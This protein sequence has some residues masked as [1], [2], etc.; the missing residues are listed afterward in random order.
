MSRPEAGSGDA[1]TRRSWRPSAG[2]G[3]ARPSI[4]AAKASCGVI[5]A[6]PVVV[7][8]AVAAQAG[9]T[10]RPMMRSPASV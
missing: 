6:L 2:S 3:I 10:L 5:V 7:A 4:S 8:L 9:E 1:R